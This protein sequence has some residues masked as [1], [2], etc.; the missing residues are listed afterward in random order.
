MAFFLRQHANTQTL[1]HRRSTVCLHNVSH[2]I[3]VIYIALVDPLPILKILTVQQQPASRPITM[4]RQQFIKIWLPTAGYTEYFWVVIKNSEMKCTVIYCSNGVGIMYF[5]N[6][7][8]CELIKF[9]V[10]PCMSWRVKTTTVM[11]AT[12]EQVSDLF[13]TLVRPRQSQVKAK[14][15]GL[16]LMADTGGCRA[17][18]FDGRHCR[19]VMSARVLVF[20]GFWLSWA[21]GKLASFVQLRAFDDNRSRSSLPAIQHGLITN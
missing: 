20:F 9:S 4:T 11:L 17:S 2:A 1:K 14:T 16:I 18:F 12:D 6:S 5:N 3:V 10:V 21:S 7:Q 15:H 8:F 13:R 19:R